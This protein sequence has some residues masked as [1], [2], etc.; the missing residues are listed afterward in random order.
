ME[1]KPKVATMFT[2]AYDHYANAIFRYCYFKT[3]D[4]E[5]A[6]DLMQ[7]T[8]LQTWS[9]LNRGEEIRDFRPF[10]YRIANNLVVDWYRQ[11]KADSLDNLLEQGFNLPDPK[12]NPEAEVELAWVFKV[13]DQL[14]DKDK[15]LVILRQVE[16]LP[17]KEI[18]QMIGENENNTAVKIHRAL[19]KLRDLLKLNKNE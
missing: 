13:L 16:G 17:I 5:L 2:A 14:E 18:G 6:K 4:R 12:T 11:K 9:Y 7:Q 19:K 15:E 8:F 10:L 1:I 3:S